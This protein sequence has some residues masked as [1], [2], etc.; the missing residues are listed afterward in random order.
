MN[1]SITG[2]PYNIKV[3]SATGA[4]YNLS[5]TCLV[6]ISGATCRRTIQ[7]SWRY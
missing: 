5:L 1:G 2:A 6:N 4:L 3:Q 7:L